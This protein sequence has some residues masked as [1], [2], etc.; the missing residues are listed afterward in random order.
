[1]TGV[2]TSY[3]F[4][5]MVVTTDSPARSS[6]S[7]ARTCSSLS[8]RS[9]LATVNCA[10]PWKSI[11]KLRPP[12][13][14]AT[15]PAS[16]KMAE[17][18]KYSFQPPT[19]STFSNTPTSPCLLRRR[20]TRFGDPHQ[21]GREVDA[22]VREQPEECACDHDGREHRE[23]DPDGE[24][25]GEAPDR[26]AGEREQD[27]RCNERRYV[28]VQNRPETLV[29]AGLDRTPRRLAAPYLLLDALED[30]DVGIGCDPDGEHDAGDPRQRHRNRDDYDQTPQ[31]ERVDEQIEVG[32]D[33]ERPVDYE[34]Q[35]EHEPEP[36]ERG[37]KPALQGTQTER[38][39]YCGLGDHLHVDGKRAGV[40]HGLQLPGLVLGKT[41]RQPVVGDRD[42]LTQWFLHGRR[43]LDVFVERDG[44]PGRLP[45]GERVV[46]HL[47]GKFPHL[48]ATLCC[49][50]QAHDALPGGLV[51][52][53]VSPV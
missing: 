33:A 18:E 49:E 36:D 35:Q 6:G 28:A 43:A 8:W 48:P 25:H 22:A 4:C 44:E 47:L 27:E 37:Q 26:S 14:M 39:T 13:A 10:P 7:A 3:P 30:D 45:A 50:L 12:R 11:P 52:L 5:P 41:I 21:G 20:D 42:I 24:Q 40:E 2:R 53:H 38:R 19:K 32:D 31:Q 46:H 1:M 51:E 17:I 23:H 34:Q 16:N 9:A 15:P 29:V